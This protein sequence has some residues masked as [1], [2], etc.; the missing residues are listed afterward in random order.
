MFV[1]VVIN[2]QVDN[3]EVE[4]EIFFLLNT[5]QHFKTFWFEKNFQA[6]FIGTKK[7]DYMYSESYTYLHLHKNI[8]TDQVSEGHT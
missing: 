7:F 8:V 4:I 6:K 2:S 1:F 5:R 3:F